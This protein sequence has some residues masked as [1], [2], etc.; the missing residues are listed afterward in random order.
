MK[1]SMGLLSCIVV[2]LAVLVPTA[3]A[4]SSSTTDVIGTIVYESW[5]GSWGFAAADLYSISSD[6]TGEQKLTSDGMASE[7]SPEWSPDRTRLAYVSDNGTAFSPTRVQPSKPGQNVY[8]SNADGTNPRRITKAKGN[9]SWVSPSWSPDGRKLVVGGYNPVNYTGAIYSVSADGTALRKITR[10]PY[11]QSPKWSP[12]GKWIVFLR[13]VEESGQWHLHLVRPD[14]SGLRRLTQGSSNILG[15]SWSPDSRHIAY[16][17]WEVDANFVTVSGNVHV[18]DIGTGKVH[19]VTRES[20]LNESPCWSPDGT[21]IA[22][23][24]S[25]VTFGAFAYVPRGV[26]GSY[27]GW[28][29]AFFQP[30]TDLYVI[31]VDGTGLK[32]L[33][34]SPQSSELGCDWK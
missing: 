23:A 20:G 17:V 4:R 11:D 10:G 25:P 19:Q 27:T 14:G 12:D 3:P 28:V 5:V 33:T 24:H 7:M 34:N 30:G 13:F 26:T 31:N 32:Q 29:G 9:K 8:V 6:G 16:L 1:R 18:I 2:V 15:P 22:F 21:R